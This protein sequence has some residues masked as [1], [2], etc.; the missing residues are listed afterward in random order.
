MIGSRTQF[1]IHDFA[2]KD[3]DLS[4]LT[5]GTSGDGHQWRGIAGVTRKADD[6]CIAC[7][8]SVLEWERWERERRGRFRT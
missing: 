2:S 4:V 5:C 7:G 6:H 8:C 3:I 1:A